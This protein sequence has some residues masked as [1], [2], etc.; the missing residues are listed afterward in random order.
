M[1]KNVYKFKNGIK[2]VEFK[3]C[4]PQKLPEQLI[5]VYKYWLDAFK[6]VLTYQKER[7]LVEI[8]KITTDERI[9]KG[10]KLYRNGHIKI[11]NVTTE[12]NG[13]VYAVVLSEDKKREY[14]VVIKNY[15]PDGLPQYNY[16]RE[17]YIANLVV[18][19]TCP[20]H[21]FGRYRSNVSILCGHIIAVLFYLIEHF[22]M[23][24]IFI[25][26]EEKILG[27]KKSNVEEISTNIKALPLLK[28][29][30]YM[31][32]LLLKK[33][34]GMKPALSISIHKLFNPPYGEGEAGKPL[35]LTFTKA[36]DVEKM[37]KAL[38]EVHEK[39]IGKP[40]KKWW[41]IWK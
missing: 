1:K 16:E 21:T 26:P 18:Y 8:H 38:K 6:T 22:N 40:K 3:E 23:P 20:D 34:R 39:M 27:V 35:W 11:A 33:F 24:K 19:C 30:Y 29:T 37:I 25:M 9:L 36:E 28:Y 10:L 14:S 2:T 17:R 12:N 5:H 32:I 15:L 31:N 41:E 4:H 13:D 7:G